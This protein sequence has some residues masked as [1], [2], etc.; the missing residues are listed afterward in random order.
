MGLIQALD[1]PRTGGG[2]AQNR[3]WMGLEQAVNVPRTGSGWAQNRQWMGLEQ[4]TYGPRTGSGWGQNK[5]LMGLEQAVDGLRTGSGWAQNRSYSP[6]V[7]AVCNPVEEE[8]PGAG[9][10]VGHGASNKNTKM[11]PGNSGRDLTGFALVK[12]FNSH[13]GVLKTIQYKRNV[14]K[15]FVNLF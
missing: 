3:Q 12:S 4:A 1:G 11:S 14:N 15:K 8:A 10:C 6:E 2:W 13:F 7:A 9:E 5:Q